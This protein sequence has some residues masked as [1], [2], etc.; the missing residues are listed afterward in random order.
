MFHHGIPNNMNK[1]NKCLWIG[2]GEGCNHNNII[3]RSYC[4]KHYERIYISLLPEMAQYLV[5]KEVKSIF[6]NS[7]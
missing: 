2:D 1:E 4:E 6:Q 5:D 7:N 3:G